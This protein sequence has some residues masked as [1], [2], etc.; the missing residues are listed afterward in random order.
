[1]MD[2]TLLRILA[3]A[4]RSL[5]AVA[6]ACCAL[7]AAAFNHERVV[8]PIAPGRF[9]VACSNIA[10][11]ASRIAPGASASDYWE[12]RPVN[13]VDHYITEILASPQSVVRFAAR[14]PGERNHYPGHAGEMVDFVAI[15]CYP[16]SRDNNYPDSPLPGT[17][18]TIPHMQPA[19]ASPWVIGFSEYYQTLGVAAPPNPPL[20]V[21]LP[22][23]VFSHGLTGSPISQGYVGALVALAAQGFVVAAPFHGDPRFSRVRVQDL[24]D[25]FYLL[26]NFDHVVE[27]QLMRPLSLKAMTDVLLADP[28]LSASINANVIGGFGAS[29]GGE[30]LALPLGAPM[31][32]SLGLECSDPVHDPRIKAAVGYVPFGGYPFLPA[33]CEGQGGAAGVNRPYLAISGTADTTAPLTTMREALNRFGSSRYMV[34]L[35]DGQHELRPEDVGDLFTWMVT[36]LRAYLGDGTDPDAMAHFIRMNGVVGG[37]EDSLV[38]DVHVPFPNAGGE[39]TVR[40]FYNSIINH[41]LVTPDAAEI[42]AIL[43][44]DAGA[45]WQSTGQAFKAWPQMPSD[46]FTGVA[47]VCRFRQPFRSATSSAFFTASGSECDQVKISRGWHYIG[48]SFY[49]LPAIAGTGCPDGYFGVNR[50]YNNGAVRNDSSHRY[51]TSDSEMRALQT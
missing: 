42:H 9:I 35:V 12:G 38:V 2:S 29:L 5:A 25:F 21:Q 19:G 1:M 16:T 31:T 17:G 24:S 11:D 45:G 28:V 32:P 15:V 47:P 10:Q 14:V 26:A 20:A 4:L 43:R 39:E 30:A 23:I 18:E 27:M 6:V 34:Q 46:A 51:T 33:F 36:F 40:E 37:R 7:P 22:L 13:G 50:A 41:Y 44:G 48:T 8:A 49:I 3:C